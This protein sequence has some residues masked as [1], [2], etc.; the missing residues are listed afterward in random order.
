RLDFERFS[1]DSLTEYQ[2]IQQDVLRKYTDK[3]ITTNATGLAT[4]SINYYDS[5]KKLDA[6]GFDYYP[7]LR[8]KEINSL[9]YAFARGVCDRDFWLVEFASGG[10]HGLRGSGRLQP[11]PGALKQSVIHAFAS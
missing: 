10:G 1:S 7:S 11:H 9:P 6:Y 8:D 4:N 5:F 3:T 2:D